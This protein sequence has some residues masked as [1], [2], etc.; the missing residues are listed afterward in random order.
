MAATR[1]SEDLSYILKSDWLFDSIQQSKN[2]NHTHDGIEIDKIFE[3][4]PMMNF[5]LNFHTKGYAFASENIHKIL[6]VTS[7]ELIAGGISRSLLLFDK[8]HR[9]VFSNEMLPLMFDWIK[10]F[11]ETGEDVRRTKITYNVYLLD[12]N[13][14]KISTMHILKP[15]T[16]DNNRLPVLAVKY[17]IDISLHRPTIQPDLRFECLNSKEEYEILN[18]ATF[19]SSSEKEES[20]SSREQEILSLVKKGYASKEI[21]NRLSLSLHTVNNH[22]KN[23]AH[24]CKVKSLHQITNPID[25]PEAKFEVNSK[26]VDKM[27]ML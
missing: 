13:G 26:R 19:Y 4:S 20:L 16:I 10:T 12:R 23:I 8:A 2:E 14:K 9:E 18:C 6:G 7:K 22:R 15:I 1:S 5:V 27:A 24:K 17:I 3:I 25:A 11:S 21:A